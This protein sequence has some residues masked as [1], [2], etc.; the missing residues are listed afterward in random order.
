M[1]KHI[2]S[3]V[4]A[5]VMA[6]AAFTAQAASTTVSGGTIQFIGS[7]ADAPCS[8]SADSENGI[9]ML[10][11]V[12]LESLGDPGEAS[13]QAKAFNI[14]LEDCAVTTTLNATV[15][16]NGQSTTDQPGALANN[17]G[18]GAATGV[19]LQLYGPDGKAMALGD[20]SAPQELSNGTNKIPLSVD[21]V[22]TSATTATAGAVESVATF[23]ITYS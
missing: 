7:V 8:V 12:T 13:G 23:Q 4:V 14:E 16:F 19:A 22:R 2:L 5:S 9:V 1:N 20:A 15:T 3:V 18:S 6:S 21:Y 11:Q 17:A 10:D